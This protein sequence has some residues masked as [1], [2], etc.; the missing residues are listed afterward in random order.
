MRP[1]RSVQAETD[2]AATE[3]ARVEQLD[4]IMDKGSGA[5]VIQAIAALVRSHNRAELAAQAGI[6]RVG[7]WKAIKDDGD[8]RFDTVVRILDALGMRLRVEA[9]ERARAR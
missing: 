8:P 7:L 5:E 4:A 2:G 6:S 3:G 1:S 9:K